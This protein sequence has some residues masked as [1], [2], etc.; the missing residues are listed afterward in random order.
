MTPET[1]DL[2]LK[3]G[4]AEKYGFHDKEKFFHKPK[5]GLSRKVVEERCK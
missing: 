1:Q 5:K 4:Y 3:K 2:D